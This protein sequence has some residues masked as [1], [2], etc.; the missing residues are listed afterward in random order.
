MKKLILLLLF[1]PLVSCDYSASRIE[2]NSTVS[3][4]KSSTKSV[5][6]LDWLTGQREGSHDGGI[7]EQT[8]LP[9]R[10]GTITALVR[11]TKESDTRFVEIIHIREINGSLELNLQIFNNSLEPENISATYSRIHKFELYEIGDRY[12]AFKGVSDGAHRSLSYQRSEG[13]IFSINIETNVGD[14]FEIKLKPII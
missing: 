5:Y 1:I 13:D 10:S 7:L 14:R 9:P 6:Q 11:S 3:G 2:E 4:E 12:L 8:W